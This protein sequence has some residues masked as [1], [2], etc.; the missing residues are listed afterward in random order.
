MTQICEGEKTTYLERLVFNNRKMVILICTLVTVFLAFQA[1]QM[2]PQTSFEKMIPLQHPF[3]V[4]MMGNREDLGGGNSIRIALQAKTGDIFDKEY[5]ETLR[6]MQDELFYMP[7]VERS[8][9]RSLWSAGVRWIEVTEEG[10]TGGEVIPQTYNGDAQSLE[11]LRNNLL[12]SGQIGRMVGNNFKSSI[13]EVPLLEVYPDPDDKGKLLNLDYQEFSHLLEQKLR[14]KYQAQNPNVEI[15]IVG[16]AKK[17]GDLIDGL[18]MVV[19]FFFAA[20]MITLVLL[21]WFTRCMRST[22]SVFTCGRCREAFTIS[23]SSTSGSQSTS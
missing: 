22:I 19:T 10:F 7:G 15:H 4:N 8:G 13:I 2:R 11:V 9:L 1:M 18:T 23:V 16:F 12:K 20:F 5:M 3:I 21:Y 17:V 14:D 6:Q